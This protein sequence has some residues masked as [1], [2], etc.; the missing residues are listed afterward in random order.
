MEGQQA[1]TSKVNDK[2][3]VG[4]AIKDNKVYAITYNGFLYV[5]NANKR[6]EKWLNL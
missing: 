6:V 1:D 3:F 4:V 5:F 2:K